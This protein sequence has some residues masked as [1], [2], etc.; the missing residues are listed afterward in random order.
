[1]NW[2]KTFSYCINQT[3]TNLN[4]TQQHGNTAVEMK[5][6]QVTN[7]QWPICAQTGAYFL[8]WLGCDRSV[9]RWTLLGG[10][11]PAYDRGPWRWSSIHGSR[12]KTENVHWKNLGIRWSSPCKLAQHEDARWCLW[13]GGHHGRVT[14]NPWGSRGSRPMR[15]QCCGLN[16]ISLSG[17]LPALYGG[18]VGFQPVFF[19][20][21]GH[22]LCPNT[23]V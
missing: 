13:S 16:H 3:L 19:F 8:R 9:F 6:N 15:H 10:A 2:V 12:E 20:H 7:T 5:T 14:G 11:P 21:V 18:L 1:M 17:E 23:G 22:S 4:G